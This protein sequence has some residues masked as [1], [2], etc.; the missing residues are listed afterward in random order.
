MYYGPKQKIQ[1]HFI[2]S[3]D[4]YAFHTRATHAQ[5]TH[6]QATYAQTTQPPSVAKSNLKGL[7]WADVASTSCHRRPSLPRLN[8]NK[9]DG[10]P[11]ERPMPVRV[12]RIPAHDHRSSIFNIFWY[13]IFSVCVFLYYYIYNSRHNS[14]YK[15]W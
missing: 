2:V 3:G 9:L 6:V 10:T 1:W 15:S 4:N 11:F 7:I 13:L 12:E 5:A 14:R 8:Q